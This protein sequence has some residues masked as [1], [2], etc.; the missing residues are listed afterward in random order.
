MNG[1]HPPIPG[2]DESKNRGAPESLDAAHFADL[3]PDV[4][5][6]G[7]GKRRARAFMLANADIVRYRHYLCAN[8]SRRG[9]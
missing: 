1:Q 7:A 3:R 2:C 9:C 6:Q 5:Q 4:T 8:M